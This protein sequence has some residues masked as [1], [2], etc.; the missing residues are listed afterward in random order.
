MSCFNAIKPQWNLETWNPSFMRLK[1]VTYDRRT[2]LDLT[3]TI[4]ICL[5]ERIAGPNT[6]NGAKANQRSPSSTSSLWKISSGLDPEPTILANYGTPLCCDTATRRLL[7]QK[8]PSYFGRNFKKNLGSLAI[9]PFHSSLGGH[10]VR[11]LQT[12]VRH[13]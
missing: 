5:H 11:I 1:E 8:I 10:K 13:Y 7:E 4:S 12:L 9:G 3:I 2:T 6:R